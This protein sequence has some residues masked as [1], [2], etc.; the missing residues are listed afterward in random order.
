MMTDQVAVAYG[1]ALMIGGLIGFVRR[2]SKIS[3]LAGLI[4]GSWSTYNAIHPSR[5]TSVTNLV[6]AAVLGLTMFIRYTKSGKW[7]PSLIIVAF[8][9]VIIYRNHGYL[10]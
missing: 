5:H 2:G 4:L 6:I 9:A 8:S 10:K 3:L 7:F 1:I